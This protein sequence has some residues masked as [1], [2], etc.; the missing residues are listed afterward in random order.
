MHIIVIQIDSNLNTTVVGLPVSHRL[1]CR[2]H[3]SVF[4]LWPAILFNL[5]RSS[6]G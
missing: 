1:L 6:E 4:W 5:V 3:I 2:R